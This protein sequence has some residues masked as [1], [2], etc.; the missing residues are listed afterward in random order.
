VLF[1]DWDLK[2][3]VSWDLA[4]LEHDAVPAIAAAATAATA[5]APASGIAAA[6]ARGTPSRAEC[7][8]DL[9]LGGLGEFGAAD[10]MKEP[11]APAAAAVVPSAS[12]M[13][14]PRSG[15]AGAGGGAQCPS[16][17]VDGCKADLGK[18]RDYHRRHKVCEAHSKTP[19]VVVA[20]REMR[21]CQQCSRYV[22]DNSTPWQL[23]PFSNSFQFAK[24]HEHP[25]HNL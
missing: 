10:R 13:K 16:C 14:R 3:P 23:Q 21:F 11:A 2:M 12:P 19:V 6:A 1:M 4:E 9:K 8:V 15:G 7:S 25:L 20:G 22:Y 18:C 24:V 5:A 17:A